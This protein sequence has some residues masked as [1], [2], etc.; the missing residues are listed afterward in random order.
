MSTNEGSEPKESR[1]VKTFPQIADIVD[2]FYGLLPGEMIGAVKKGQATEAGV[3]ELRENIDKAQGL[4]EQFSTTRMVIED[5]QK[6][7]I[8]FTEEELEEMSVRD[9]RGIAKTH[10]IRTSQLK[11]ELVAALE[12]K[13]KSRP[14]LSTKYWKTEDGRSK[15]VE[16]LREAR[17]AADYPYTGNFMGTA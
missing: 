15:L 12:G 7:P 16:R 5:K 9:L 1:Q 3:Q 4:W 13:P 11:R 8:L 2:E 17:A 6:Q 14:V 10:G